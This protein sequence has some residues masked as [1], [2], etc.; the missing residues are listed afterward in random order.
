[1][2][3]I[4]LPCAV[5]KFLLA[6]ISAAVLCYSVVGLAAQTSAGVVAVV[7]GVG[8]SRDHFQRVVDNARAAMETDEEP[9][10]PAALKQLQRDV[11]INLIR[12]EVG[13]QEGRRQGIEV[14]ASDVDQRIAAIRRRAPYASAY[15]EALRDSG[16]SDLEMQRQT[17]KDIVV[18]RLIESNV[19]VGLEVTPE[20]VR[21]YYDS[22]P[23]YFTEPERVHLRH[24]LLKVPEDADAAAKQ[25][26]REQMETILQRLQFGEEFAALAMEFSDDTSAPQG[27]DIGFLARKELP[28]AIAD[29]AF[30]LQPGEFSETVSTDLGFHL[31]LLVERQPELRTPFED[32]REAISRD[33]LRRKTELAAKVYLDGLVR[34]ADVTSFIK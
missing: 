4:V 23:Q 11:L 25:R 27:G 1:M 12:R 2:R 26:L 24:L 20:D 9:L 21:Y 15:A 33:L 14:S 8:I 29:A 6:V 5:K 32:V 22:N 7:N 19:S 34:D 3:Q 31:V 18:K 17:E 13:V 10:P 30:G 16:I 28:E